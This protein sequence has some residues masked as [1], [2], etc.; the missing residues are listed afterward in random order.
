MLCSSI[1]WCQCQPASSSPCPTTGTMWHASRAF[2]PEHW[3]TTLVVEGGLSE[4]DFAGDD[5]SM[6][7]ALTYGS[8]N[9]TDI[10][11]GVGELCVVLARLV[12]EFD[13]AVPEG[14]IIQSWNPQ[15]IYR[16]RDKEPLEM[17]LTS[18]PE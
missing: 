18:A 5:R 3:L 12:F 7:H 4:N 9:C 15:E 11:P 10:K 6:Y 8:R 17:T 13:I 14:T 16:A 2:P 1:R